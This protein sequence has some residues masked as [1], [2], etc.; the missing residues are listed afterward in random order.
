MAGDGV[1]R[2]AKFHQDVM[3]WPNEGQF[4]VFDG[5]IFIQKCAF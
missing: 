1:C 3:P 4:D 2:S 5:M